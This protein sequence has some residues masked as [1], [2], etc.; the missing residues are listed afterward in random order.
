MDKEVKVCTLNPRASVIMG[1]ILDWG[2]SDEGKSMNFLEFLFCY[3]KRTFF[4]ALR[5]IG[6]NIGNWKMT[7]AS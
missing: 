4:K 1:C 3:V 6:T 2:E 5:L 7:M